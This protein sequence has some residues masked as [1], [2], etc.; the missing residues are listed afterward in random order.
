MAGM[1]QI[2]V[3]PH[4]KP[5][6]LTGGFIE[7]FERTTQTTFN[8]LAADAGSSVA[9]STTLENGCAVITTGAVDNNEA[10]IYSNA[11]ASLAAG[12]PTLVYVRLQ[13]A[14]ANVN[15]ANILVM[16]SNAA[17]TADMLIDNGGGPIAAHSGAS[18]YKV[19]GGTRW[20][21][22]AQSAVAGSQQ[23][24]DTEKTAGGAGYQTLYMLINPISSSEF[25]V[26]P[27]IDTAG[28]NN[29]IQPFKFGA[30][31]GRD[32]PIGP[33]I[34]YNANVGLRL[35][36]HAKAGGANSEVLNVDLAILQK[37]R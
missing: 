4:V 35:I 13:Y 24:F 8:T 10:G 26:E 32:I 34:P 19:D 36:V 15:A 11:I 33:R 22:R 31:P 16:L 37:R 12:K 5:L 1:S 14:E 27:W 29:L 25:L 17:G 9:I 3:L 6:L 30:N 23:T 7:D 20:Q 18:F 28:L 2:N 21:F